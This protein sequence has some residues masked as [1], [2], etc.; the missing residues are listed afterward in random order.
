MVA[1]GHPLATWSALD[2]LSRGGTA[3]D[4]AI[5]A[6][7]VMGVVEPMASGVGGDLLAQI[8]VPGEAPVA[9]QRDRS[10]SAGF[11][12]GSHRGCGAEYHSESAPAV[13]DGP[14]RGGGMVRPTRS[15]WELAYDRVASS[16]DRA[17]AGGIPGR[18]FRRA[19]LEELRRRH[20]HVPDDG[21]DFSGPRYSE[22]GRSV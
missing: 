8:I 7:A 20:P 14:R 21:A 22:G 12:P 11:D 9:Y 18:P 4:A 13:G 3:V 5:S 19:W 2:V 6:D 16:R 15:I 17:G 1:S 10:G